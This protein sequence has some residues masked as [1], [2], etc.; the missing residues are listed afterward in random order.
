MLSALFG[1]R[2]AGFPGGLKLEG[3]KLYGEAGRSRPAPLPAELIYPLSQHAGAAARPVVS[4]GDTV[5]RGD[6]LARADGLVSAA[7]HARTSG[8]IAAIEERPVPH[9]SGLRAPC[10][11]LKAD[12]EDRRRESPLWEPLANPAQ[13]VPEDL[14][15]LIREAGIA[16]II[17][18]KNIERLLRLC[19]RHVMLAKG[20]VV[21]EGTSTDLAAQPEVLHRHLGV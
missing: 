17:V 21:F 13:A 20:E 1:G 18:D 11:V 8:T 4:V 14:I 15:A 10:I 5:L 2:K 12:G 19:D 3:H 7:I 16:C 9:A 6:L